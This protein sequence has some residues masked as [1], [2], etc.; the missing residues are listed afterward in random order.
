MITNGIV[1]LSTE[2]GI[3]LYC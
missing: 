2:Q 1:T 3:T